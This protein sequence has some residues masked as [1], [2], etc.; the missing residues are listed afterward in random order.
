[1]QCFFP[2]RDL[3][4]FH[5]DS[6]SIRGALTV[7]ELLG[8]LHGDLLGAWTLDGDTITFWE[9]DPAGSTAGAYFLA[10]VSLEQNL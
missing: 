7:G 8:L 9:R 5:S 2:S 1:M 4:F 6:L 3:G 10:L